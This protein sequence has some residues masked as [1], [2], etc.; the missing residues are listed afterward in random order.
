VHDNPFAVD[1][2]STWMAWKTKAAGVDDD[3]TIPIPNSGMVRVTRD[4]V[5]CA[6]CKPL[7][8]LRCERGEAP[9]SQ[10]DME[11]GWKSEHRHMNGSWSMVRECAGCS[12]D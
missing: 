1:H 6:W 2:D 4:D 5:L 11:D 7:C 9:P 8:P 12:L 3:S 10:Q